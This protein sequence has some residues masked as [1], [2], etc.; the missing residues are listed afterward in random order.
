MIQSVAS[1]IVIGVLSVMV[2]LQACNRTSLPEVPVT[3]NVTFENHIKPITSTV[4]IECHN[5]RFRDYS[6]YNNAF[7]VRYAIH[8][9]VVVDKTMP[10]GK[11]L[12][13]RDRALF[14][15]WVNQGG[16]K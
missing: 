14:R 13:D 6:N 7:S 2:G 9:K 5:G 11:Y 12:S 15:D 1:L 16:K 4:C 3:E 10:L 8:Q